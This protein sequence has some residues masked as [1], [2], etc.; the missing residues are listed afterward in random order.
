[1]IGGTTRFLVTAE[2][3]QRMPQWSPPLIGGTTLAGKRAV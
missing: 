3:H 1:L 2:S